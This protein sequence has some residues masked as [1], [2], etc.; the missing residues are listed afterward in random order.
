MA[1]PFVEGHLWGRELKGTIDTECA[2]CREPIRIEVSS[3][4]RARSLTEGADPLI[5]TPFVKV[6]ELTPSIIDGF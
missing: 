4:L 5:S 3:I 2:H 6:S 1:T